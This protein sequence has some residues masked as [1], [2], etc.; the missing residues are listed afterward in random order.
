MAATQKAP[1]KNHVFGT[2]KSRTSN[3][4][5]AFANPR[6]DPG[7][8]LAIIL[9]WDYSY[10]TSLLGIRDALHISTQQ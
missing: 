9:S 8:I 6:S 10:F 3:T 5:Y 2:P 1:Y 7:H 4:L